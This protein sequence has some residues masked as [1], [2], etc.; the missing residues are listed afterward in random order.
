[1]FSRRE[2]IGCLSKVILSLGP[3]AS[4]VNARRQIGEFCSARFQCAD[5]TQ[6]SA[7]IPQSGLRIDTGPSQCDKRCG[8]MFVLGSPLLRRRDRAVEA[9]NLL[10]EPGDALLAILAKRGDRIRANV[11]AGQALARIGQAAGDLLK[12]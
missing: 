1:V 5:L 8:D 2:I 12:S 4:I 10:V 7:C 11:F 9:N 6:R 3:F